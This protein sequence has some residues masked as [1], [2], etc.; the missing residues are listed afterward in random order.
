ME[1]NIN[2]LPGSKFFKYSD[3]Q[4]APEIIRIRRVDTIKN[5]V[6]YYTEDWKKESMTYDELIKDYRKLRPDG[7]MMFSIVKVQEAP[8]VIVSLK[9]LSDDNNAPNPKL[10]DVVCR[11][12]IQDCF[13][14]L[15]RNGRNDTVGVS[16]SQ[17]T[18]PANIDFATVLMCTEVK[19]NYSLAVYLDDSLNDILKFISEKK[20]NDTLI[21]L[22]N[23]SLRATPMGMLPMNG[24]TETIRELLEINNFMY[25]FRSCFGITEVPFH[26]P[27]DK[28]FLNIEN[29]QY[30]ENYLKVNILE[31]YLIKYTKEIDLRTI[32]RDYLLVSSAEDKHDSVYIVGY[33]K[34]DGDYIPRS[35]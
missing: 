14:N 12:S 5:K 27:E 15:A 10:P 23:M 7:A 11:Q 32:K 25:D 24:Y 13:T 1:N 3:D 9:N 19:R 17:K 33:D 4:D 6:S 30:L 21:S 26:I 22:K 31:T 18:C 8:D 29:V 16:I 20:Y 28:E 2:I 34:A 35:F